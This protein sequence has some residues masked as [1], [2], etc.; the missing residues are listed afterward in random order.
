[1]QRLITTI[2][3]LL[4]EDHGVVYSPCIVEAMELPPG[5]EFLLPDGR[6][7]HL[8]QWGS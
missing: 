2:R 1:M 3:E 4:G 6:E 7:M 8:L 5:D